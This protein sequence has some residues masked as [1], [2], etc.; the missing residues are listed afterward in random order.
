MEYEEIPYP[1]VRVLVSKYAG[2]FPYYRQSRIYTHSAFKLHRSMLA[3][4]DKHNSC[5][6]TPAVDVLRS[7]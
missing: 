4:S 2:H 3:D 6:V 7:R 1:I 5:D